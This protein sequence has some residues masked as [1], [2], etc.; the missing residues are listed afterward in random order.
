M[1]SMN[2]QVSDRVT[3]LLKQVQAA[4][5]SASV[6]E[7]LLRLMEEYPDASLVKH[8]QDFFDAGPM[9]VPPSEA[10]AD[11]PAWRAVMMA[12]LE[13]DRPVL[14]RSKPLTR[15]WWAAAAIFIS[16]LAGSIYRFQQK[17][18]TQPVAIVDIP[19]GSNGAIL[20]LSDGST[21]VL[22]SLANGQVAQQ[23]GANVM[24]QNGRLNYT[25][26]GKPSGSLAYNIMTTPKG[27]QFQLTLPDGTKV[28]LNA[29]SSIRYPTAFT[30]SDRSVA[31]SGEVYLEV[32]GDPHRPF[33]VSIGDTVE[34]EVLGTR[35][36]VNAYTD[37]PGI[38]T[39]LLQGAVKVSTRN[40]FKILKPGEQAQMKGAQLSILKNADPAHV[41][42]WKDG[43]FSFVQADLPTVMR[44]LARWYDVEVVFAGD[45]P[46]RSITGEI[47]RSLTLEQVLKGLTKLKINYK[48]EGKK[49]IIQP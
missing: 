40:Q 24:L 34:V 37:E 21:V 14:Q 22:D 36:N 7:E 47:G 38:Y 8:I 23:Q 39:T 26:T 46:Q 28:W 32:A 6:Y 43:A 11:E 10:S 25:P 3:A 27:R 33:R 35:F 41:T 19:P 13:S 49:L 29:A 44:Q 18:A 16:I 20:T 9:H 4:K 17:P 2:R 45:I 12:V 5:A 1:N 42:A 48:I 15:W 30:G 31:I